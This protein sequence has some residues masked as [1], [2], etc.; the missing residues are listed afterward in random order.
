MD[1]EAF[2]MSIRKFLKSVGVQSQHEIEAAIA[3]AL[4][5]GKIKGNESLPARMTLTIE[6]AGVVFSVEGN[7]DL[8]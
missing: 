3:R 5:A 6:R 2:N 7:I 1:Q 8:E 4:A